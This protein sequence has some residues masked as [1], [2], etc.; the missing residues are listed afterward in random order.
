MG[1]ISINKIG[2]DIS[3]KSERIRNKK[4]K[5]FVENGMK[6]IGAQIESFNP[7]TMLGI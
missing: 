5:Q 7:I 4:D 6:A 2:G 3:E 1:G